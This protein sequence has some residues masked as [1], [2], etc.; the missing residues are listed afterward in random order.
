MNNLE[1]LKRWDGRKVALYA[2]YYGI[3]LSVDGILR[4]NEKSFDIDLPNGG[5]IVNY[6][7]IGVLRVDEY[8][9][10]LMI[11]GFWGQR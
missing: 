8:S 7:V 4:L 3:F 1:I 2:Q 11:K 6:P 9:S 10:Y 5:K